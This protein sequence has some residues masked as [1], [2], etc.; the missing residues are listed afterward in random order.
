ML[1]GKALF[2]PAFRKIIQCAVVTDAMVANKNKNG[3]FK[4]CFF[5]CRFHK[6]LKTK[7]GVAESIH[8]FITFKTKTF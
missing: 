1:T 5:F 4:I 7:I 3:I 6:F 8:L 2:C